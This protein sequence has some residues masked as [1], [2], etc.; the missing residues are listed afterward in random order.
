[1]KFF[2]KLTKEEKAIIFHMQSNESKFATTDSYFVHLWQGA[3]LDEKSAKIALGK[4]I[5]RK[6][7]TTKPNKMPKE[8]NCKIFGELYRLTFEGLLYKF[9]NRWTILTAI[10]ITITTISAA[11]VMWITVYPILCDFTNLELL[12]CDE[13]S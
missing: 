11:I 13:K 5:E 4:L 6:L 7:I 3:G 10:G 1:M 9:T 8:E 12:F 2:K